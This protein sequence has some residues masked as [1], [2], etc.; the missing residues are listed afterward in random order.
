MCVFF[1]PFHIYSF[2]LDSREHH[3]PGFDL[4]NHTHSGRQSKRQKSSLQADSYLSSKC[5]I[6]SKLGS[7]DFHPRQSNPWS[8][9]NSPTSSCSEHLL[10]N[11]DP[12]TCLSSWQLHFKDIWKL[13]L[14][15]PLNCFYLYSMIPMSDLVF[16]SCFHLNTY[17]CISHIT[18]AR[19]LELP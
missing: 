16:L 9:L 12:S 4:L 5:W 10:Q 1:P 19:N 6:S 11:P 18:K 3:S 2:C 17:C 8:R 13:P 14:N 15:Q 7:Q